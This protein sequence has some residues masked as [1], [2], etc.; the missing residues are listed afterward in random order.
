[1]VR[2][3]WGSFFDLPLLGE[4]V[5]AVVPVD[6]FDLHQALAIEGDQVDL[7]GDAL[8][9]GRV[10]RDLGSSRDQPRV[11]QTLEVLVEVRGLDVGSSLKLAH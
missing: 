10:R 7:E 3:P 1:M 8:E 4:I 5:E 6:L 9:V 2:L 11:R